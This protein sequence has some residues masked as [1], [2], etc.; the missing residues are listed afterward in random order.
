MLKSKN[1]CEFVIPVLIVSVTNPQGIFDL[2]NFYLVE[3]IL[4]PLT[5]RSA[6]ALQ[7]EDKQKILGW[8]LTSGAKST[9]KH[10]GL[11]NFFELNTP[12][13]RRLP[14]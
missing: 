5:L 1:P 13:S 3:L 2:S 7:I 11:E 12:T 9:E 8:L 6:E 4:E 14:A 10:P